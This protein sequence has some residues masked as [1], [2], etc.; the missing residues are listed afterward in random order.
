[1]KIYYQQSWFVNLIVKL[2]YHSLIVISEWVFV[3]SK[4]VLNSPHRRQTVTSK[5]VPVVFLLWVKFCWYV[6]C[7]VLVM[8]SYIF[9]TKMLSLISFQDFVI[10]CF[11]IIW[12]DIHLWIN[13]FS[14]KQCQ[15][16]KKF[17]WD[18]K[19]RRFV[20][21]LLELDV[22]FKLCARAWWFI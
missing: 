11:I 15:A 10:Y 12:F 16:F 19:Q 20:K 7:R 3:P 17:W 18:F 14:T 6:K 1:M 5:K 8:H 4:D 9:L 21:R 13:I 22:S 2:L